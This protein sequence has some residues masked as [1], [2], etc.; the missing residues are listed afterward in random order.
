MEQIAA[1]IAPAAT[2][3]A[4]MM[5]AAN[6]GTRV[7]G[8]GFVIFTV[9]SIAWSIVGASSGQT[10]LIVS[11]GFLTAVNIVGI[12]R[13]LGRQATYEDGSRQAA[14]KSARAPVPTLFSAGGL[15][16]A[17]VITCDGETVGTIVDAMLRC[18]GRD[19]AYVVV[20]QGGVGG[21]GETLLGFQPRD[22]TFRSDGVQTALSSADVMLLPRLRPEAW[23][24]VLPEPQAS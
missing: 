17:P 24:A 8:W 5:T 15:I 23:P 14:R 19:I 2:M 1:W 4:A 3:I 10:N 9:G 13:W 7:T 21:M 22:L 18:D 20:S 16:G 6:L 11:N 12:W